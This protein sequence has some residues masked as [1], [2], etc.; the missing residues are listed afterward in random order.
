MEGVGKWFNSRDEALKYVEEK[1]HAGSRSFD[2]GCFQINYKWHGGNF[3]S[4]FDMF[5]PNANALYAA[6]FL[7]TL[8]IEKGDWLDAAAAYHSRTD[9]YA[10]KYRKRV[11]QILRSVPGQHVVLASHAP[12]RLNSREPAVYRAESGRVAEN[13]YPLLQASSRKAPFG[14]LVPLAES[15]ATASG[16]FAAAS[17]E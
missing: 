1:Y 11:E 8:Y 13:N 5:D 17:E 12:P 9:K 10:L 3:A 16:F 4:L 6:R 14:S 2:V 15:D 7:E